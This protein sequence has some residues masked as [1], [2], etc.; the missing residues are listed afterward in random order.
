MDNAFKRRRFITLMAAFAGLPLLAGAGHA[1]GMPEPVVWR[2]QAL[3]AP[4]MLILHHED[5][6]EA[7]RLVRRVT[8]EVA[9][10]E[11]IFSLY[12]EDSAVSELNRVGVLAAPPEELVELLGLSRNFHAATGGRFDPTVQPLWLAYARHFSRGDAGRGGPAHKIVQ[13]ALSHVG[14]DGLRFDGNRIAF[15]RPGMAITL[16]GIAQG[17]VTDRIV[18][19]LRDAGVTSSLVDMGECHAVGA[20]ADG[21]PWRIGLAADQAS[22]DPDSII[23]IVDRAVASSGSFGFAFDDEGRFGHVLDPRSGAT[24]R[25][26]KAV[27]VAAPDATTADALSTAFLLMPAEEIAAL[28]AERAGCDIHLLTPGNGRVVI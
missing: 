28:K 19:L 13:E 11:G 27:S 16:N 3:G 20:R 14:F 24:A 25:L 10:L 17:Y 18:T 4:A 21:T 5:S 9:R 1:A 15:A 7:E 23:E 22:S 26:H 8:A 12:R 2:G 6:K